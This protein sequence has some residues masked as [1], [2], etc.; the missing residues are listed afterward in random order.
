MTNSTSAT[1]CRQPR[2]SWQT[3]IGA[4]EIHPDYFKV[5]SHRNGEF[6]AIGSI[7]PI[8]DGTFRDANGFGDY[9][10]Y[11][12]EANRGRTRETAA[13]LEAS[14]DWDKKERKDEDFSD[15][16]E[17]TQMLDAPP[18]AAQQADGKTSTSR[19]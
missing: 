1:A 18:S 6:W 3:A 5:R 15:I 10:V 8:Y 13:A 9:A 12:A 4:G 14:G 11:K 19:E 16:W 7:A 17:L 2:V